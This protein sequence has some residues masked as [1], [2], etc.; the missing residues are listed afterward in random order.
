MAIEYFL[1]LLSILVIIIHHKNSKSKNVETF[2]S[3]NFNI[4]DERDCECLKLNRAPDGTCTKEK[5]PK[6]PTIPGYEDSIFYNKK[7][8]NNFKYPKK[9]KH[10]I[11][12]FV[13]EQMKNKRTGLRR[14]PPEMLEN[15]FKKE[16]RI[17]S[18]DSDT[19][20]LY[21]IFERVVDILSYFDNH[22]KPYLKYLVL[23]RNNISK[24][25]KVMKSFGID[26]KKVP[27]IYLYN[28][29]TKNLQRF[30][31]KKNRLEKQCDM[32]ERLLIFIA[33][34]DCGVLS[35]LNYLHD[36]FYGMKFEYNSKKKKWR[37]NLSQGRHPIMGGTGM[38]S[39]ID[40]NHV[41]KEYKCNKLQL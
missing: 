10:D 30:L 14:D 18:D 13:G 40:I 33:D 15:S 41:P 11:L 4:C 28:E 5:I 1:I 16:Y 6:I 8:L 34:G 38:C 17:Y 35:Y 24:D 27:A 25:R 12:I 20:E 29:H 9:R 21:E 37:A 36:P 7:A 19:M 31:I 23:N 32:L 22:T 2:V 26:Y 39:L 3:G